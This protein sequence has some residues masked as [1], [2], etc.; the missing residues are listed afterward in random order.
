MKF[1]SVLAYFALDSSF[2]YA[3][4]RS[5]ECRHVSLEVTI[6]TQ[7]D[8]H[9][10]I[11]PDVQTDGLWAHAMLL[12]SRGVEFHSIKQMVSV[13]FDRAFNNQ[14]LQTINQTINGTGDLL[15]I[16][17]YLWLLHILSDD[18]NWLRRT[19]NPSTNYFSI[20]L[21]SSQSIMHS[22]MNIISHIYGCLFVLCRFH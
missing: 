19:E 18:F 16:T 3:R 7:L 17:M 15:M 6:I 8:L 1:P 13:A 21:S 9:L 14:L 12:V 2:L 20:N 5:C 11:H 4:S 10:F 22:S